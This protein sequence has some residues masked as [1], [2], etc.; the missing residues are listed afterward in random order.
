MRPPFPPEST[1][2]QWAPPSVDLYMPL[3][4]EYATAAYRV[5]A[6]DGSCTTSVTH[7]VSTGAHVAPLLL[8]LSSPRQFAAKFLVVA[9]NTVEA[10]GEPAVAASTRIFDIDTLP[11]TCAPSWVQVIPPSVDRRTPQPKYES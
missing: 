10:V 5:E 3:F 1:V 4:D 7:P 9:A 8:D 11:K 6:V 2:C